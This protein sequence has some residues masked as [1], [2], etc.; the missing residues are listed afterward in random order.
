[1]SSFDATKHFHIVAG[2]W[3][4]GIFQALPGAAAAVATCPSAVSRPLTPN[5]DYYSIALI[6]SF[7][8]CGGKSV[9]FWVRHN[10]N[11]AGVSK[12]L[13]DGTCV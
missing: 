1:M 12:Y 11:E 13:S 10:T 8:S 5:C 4:Q 6:V 7:V 3:S 9:P 2:H